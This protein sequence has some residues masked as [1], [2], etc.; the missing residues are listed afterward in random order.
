MSKQHATRFKTKTLS[1]RQN[2]II[3]CNHQQTNDLR[4][5]SKQHFQLVSKIITCNHPQTNNLRLVSKQTNIPTLVTETRSEHTTCDSLQKEK[6]LASNKITCNHPQT[7]CYS[8]KK[9][10][11]LVSEIDIAMLPSTIN[12][13]LVSNNQLQSV[14]NCLFADDVACCMKAK[15]STG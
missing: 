12:M 8:Y 3:T 7:T 1:T 14:S 11:Q 4:R 15:C 9:H 10:F 6:P 13:Q 2:K 5:V